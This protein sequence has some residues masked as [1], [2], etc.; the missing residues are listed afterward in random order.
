[1]AEKAKSSQSKRKERG[2][3]VRVVQENKTEKDSVRVNN[4]FE[5]KSKKKAT[6]K[7]TTAKK[8]AKKTTVKKTTAKKATTKKATAKKTTVEKTAPKKLEEPKKE[9]KK[10]AEPVKELKK[11]AS[12]SKSVKALKEQKAPEKAPEVILP[13]QTQEAETESFETLN[14]GANLGGY[15]SKIILRDVARNRAEVE[16]QPAKIAPKKSEEATKRKRFG[17]DTFKASKQ[18]PRKLSAKEVKENEIK[19]AISLAEKLPDTGKKHHKKGDLITRFGWARLTLM[20]TCAV[21][22]V[23]ALVYFVNL[24]SADM[25]LKVAASQSGIEA[26]Y[27]DYVPRGYELSDVTSASGKV[28]MNF[29][30]EEGSFM[31]TEEASSWDSSAL[32]NNYVRENYSDDEYSVV[33]EQGL[34]IYM[35]SNWEAWVNGGLLY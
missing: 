30:S 23:F 32:L 14:L 13:E 18:K 24:T 33:I 1:M 26:T 11:P 27:P 12:F 7:K 19:R 3:N 31:I 34:T 22:A 29:K 25:S 16:N 20:I 5:A 8:T 9:L 15:E 6:A 21:T 28:T 2:L 4:N 35:G 17:I 10:A